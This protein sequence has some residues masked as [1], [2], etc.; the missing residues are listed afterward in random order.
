MDYAPVEK[1]VKEPMPTPE[2][3]IKYAPVEKNVKEPMPTPEIGIKRI[4]DLSIES[5]NLARE[6]E[7]I[8]GNIETRLFGTD[9]KDEKHKEPECLAEAIKMTNY[10]QEENLKRM[11]AIIERL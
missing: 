2:I 10:L 9:S 6:Q 11:Y 7:R 5:L 3:A 8:I 1:N 4:V